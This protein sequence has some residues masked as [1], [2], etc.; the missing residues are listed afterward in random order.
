ME[1]G[2]TRHSFVSGGGGEGGAAWLVPAIAS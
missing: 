2:G 1:G